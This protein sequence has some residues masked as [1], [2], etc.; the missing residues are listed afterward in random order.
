MQ[1]S[2]FTALARPLDISYRSNFSIIILS[3][4]ILLAGFFY[5]WGFLDNGFSDSIWWAFQAA[6]SVFL[7]WALGREIDPDVK[8]TAFLAIPFSLILFYFTGSYQWWV[9]IAMILILRV[10]NH[11]TGISVTWADVILCLGLCA[12]LCWE[13]HYLVG[14][15]FAA[16]FLA[17]NQL[18]P[19]NKL[20]K[21]FALVALVLGIISLVIEPVQLQHHAYLFTGWWI[22]AMV[23]VSMIYLL[24]IREYKRPHSTEDYR[25]QALNGNRVQTAQVIVLVFSLVIY[26]SQNFDQSLAIGP[27]WAV[28]LSV[29]LMRIYFLFMK[30]PLY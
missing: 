27:I 28:I 24:A 19:A 13:G 21:W 30:R 7:A 11:I 2:K 26:L 20:S 17:D 6:L 25:V 4:I 14:F 15:A 3:I 5:T 22:A 1:I 23:V 18:P 12:Y 9:L 8:P 10:C 16:S 29:A